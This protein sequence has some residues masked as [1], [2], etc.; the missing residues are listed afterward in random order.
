LRKCPSCG[1]FNVRRSSI[2]VSEVL[3]HHVLRSPYRCREC[4]KRFW[5]VSKRAYY[6]AGFLV[7]AVL[8]GV[9]A[10]NMADVQGARRVEP[11]PITR[12]SQTLTDTIKLAENNDALAALKLARM[13]AQGDG[14]AKNE[15]LSR[16]W[17]A[18]AAEQG[19]AEAQYEFGMALRAGRGVIQDYQGAIKWLRLAAENGYPQAQYELGLMYRSGTGI[20]VDNVKAYTWLNLAA[21]EGIPEAATT[22]DVVLRALSPEEV[23]QAQSEARRLSES[24]SEKP[25]TD[26]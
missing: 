9:I 23:L 4:G 22:R 13:Y 18:R 26:Q 15:K 14:A 21:A 8:A 3:A 11:E 25:K 10:W 24:R 20:P 7:V 5:V 6:L 12:A 19:N 16:A 2:R 17:L 1:S